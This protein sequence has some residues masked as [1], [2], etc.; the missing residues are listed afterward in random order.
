MLVMPSE[1][2]DA[3]LVD[4][5]DSSGADGAF[6]C[7]RFVEGTSKWVSSAGFAISYNRCAT[8]NADARPVPSARRPRLSQHCRDSVATAFE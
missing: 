6:T 1:G 7:S 2:T 5:Q 4:Y 3:I 8:V